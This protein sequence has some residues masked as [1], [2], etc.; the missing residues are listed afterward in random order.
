MAHVAPWKKEEV[1]NLQSLLKEK[2]VVAL[3]NVGGI[4][5]PQMLA[6][7][8][9]LREH[10]KMR[11][12]KNNL[13][14]LALEGAEADRPG[15]GELKDHMEGQTAI[16]ATDMNPFKLYKQLQATSQMMPAKAGDIA[17]EDITLEKGPTD[18]KP[19][20]VVGELQKA[21]IPAAIEGGKVVIKKTVTVVKKGEEI[22]P[23]LAAGL[24]KLDVKPIEVGLHLQAAFEDGF[25]FKPED[26]AI[27]EVAFGT[28]L[29][30][31]IQSAYNLG[32]NAPVYN[33]QTAP[34]IVT[35]VHRDALALALEIGYLSPQTADLVIGKATNQ[36]LA[37]ASLLSD[38]ALD[39]EL[40]ERLTAAPAA[41]PAAEA[42]GAEEAAEEEEEEEEEVSEEDAAA[43]LGALFG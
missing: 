12:G 14:L 33:P 2:P 15:I 43:G 10:G 3:V 11:S 1:A 30:R 19:G 13:F 22:G 8:A 9:M 35:K 36:A 27:D 25:L 17:P 7:R 37:L 34:L 5:S 42:G 21:G 41:A 23:D 32:V 18:F 4:P 28:D 31:A 20:P 16:L 38:E 24:A 26:L 39:P 6:M 29:V 40:K